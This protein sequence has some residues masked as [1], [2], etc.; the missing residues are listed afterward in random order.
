MP[1]KQ[2]NF[3]LLDGRVVMAPSFYNPTSDAV[4]LAAFVPKDV[5]TVLDVGIGTGGAS[6]CLLTHIPDAQ[7]TG[8]DI[9]QDMLDAC[10][11]NFGL[12][13]KKATLLNN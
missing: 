10:Q 3:T 7:I 6:L 12:N 5:K 9:S 2:E 11:T 13:N 4:W 8:I 1:K